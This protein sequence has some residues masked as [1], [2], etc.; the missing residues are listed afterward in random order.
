MRRLK[1][2]LSTITVLAGFCTNVYAEKPPQPIIGE[3]Y[4]GMWI[5]TGLNQEKE[6][7][8]LFIED[9]KKHLH[10]PNYM[11]ICDQWNDAPDF[12]IIYLDTPI[13]EIPKAFD[14]NTY[15]QSYSPS[16]YGNYS[17]SFSAS[18]DT[19]GSGLTPQ[20]YQNNGFT[21]KNTNSGFGANGFNGQN[22]QQDW[23]KV[24]QQRCA[25][26]TGCNS[27]DKQSNCPKPGSQNCNNSQK[28]V[29]PQPCDK[30]SNCQKPGNQK[31]TLPQPCPKPGNQSCVPQNNQKYTPQQPCNNQSNCQKPGNQNCNTNQKCVPP[32]QQNNCNNKVSPNKCPPTGQKPDCTNCQKNSKDCKDCAKPVNPCPQ[33]PICRPNTGFR[34]R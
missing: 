5:Q 27:C 10:L 18:G 29:P 24:V 11:V 19:S 4:N 2:L 3:V 7:K 8:W 26:V 9:G 14:N 20:Q 17:P 16:F 25:P 30:Q 21:Q 12:D 13:V 15:N 22:K 34:K 28:C 1:F 23:S 32:P 6:K 33:M 31:C